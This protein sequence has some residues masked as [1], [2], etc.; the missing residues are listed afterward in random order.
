MTERPATELGRILVIVPTYNE[1]ANIEKTTGRLREAVPEADILIADDTSPDG[2]GDVADHR[3]ASDD[4]GPVR[5]RR[6]RCSASVKYARRQS[7]VGQ[8]MRLR[9]K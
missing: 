3:A 5:P 4:P 6:G 1:A 2:T 8:S 9:R 7:R